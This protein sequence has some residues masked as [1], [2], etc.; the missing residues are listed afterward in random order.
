MG[1]A[2]KLEMAN[3]TAEQLLE[4]VG[5][6]DKDLEER[7]TDDDLKD[8]SLQVSNWRKYADYLGLSEA[9]IEDIEAE[10]LP[11]SVKMRLALKKWKQKNAFMAK[12][13]FLVKDVFLR[14]GD[15]EIAEKICLQL[16]SN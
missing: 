7:Y 12:F 13:R 3:V 11:P 16:K 8:L 14:C 9:E 5:L 6:V 2:Q 4:Y 1:A 10:E 15:A